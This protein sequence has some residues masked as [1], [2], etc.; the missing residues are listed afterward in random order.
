MNPD[1]AKTTLTAKKPA[2]R[3]SPPKAPPR[4]KPHS[5]NLPVTLLADVERIAQREAKGRRPNMSA[6]ARRGIEAEVKRCKAA[7]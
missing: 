4:F 1:M 6:V 3:R 7:K 2:K 5:F